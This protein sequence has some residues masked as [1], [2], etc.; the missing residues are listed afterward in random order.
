MNSVLAAVVILGGGW[1]FSKDGGQFTKVE[2]PHDW[3]IGCGFDPEAEGG[4]GK[5]PWC[6]EGVYRR[7]FEI[8]GKP[9]HARLEFDGVMSW[10]EVFVNGKKVGS[11]DYGYVG[12]NCDI[13]GVIREGANEL[14]VKAT[15]KPH[16]SR[17]YPGGGIYR[18]VRLVTAPADHVVP[19]SVFIRAASI[20]RDA[21]TIVCDWEMSKSGSR[22]KTFT[23]EKPHL[24]D[25]EDPYL[26]EVELGGERFRYGIRKAVF[27][28]DDGFH[29]NG[30]RLQLNGV[31]LHSDLGP[32]G[33]AFDRDAAKRQ[34]L[35][36][37]DLGVNAIRTSHNPPDPKFLDLCDEM[38]FVVW[39]E[40]FDKWDE[41]AA[42]KPEQQ[43]EDYVTRNLKA[44]IRRDRNHPSVICWSISNEICSRRGQYGTE[45]SMTKERVR[46]F[47]EAVRSEDTTRPVTA[48]LADLDL[49]NWD[50]TEGLDLAGWNY[51]HSYAGFHAKYPKVP[52]VYSESASAVSSQGYYQFPVSTSKVDFKAAA[53]K[54]D[55]YE[56]H[57]AWCGDI[58][59]VEFNRLDHD[60]YV[61]GEFVWTGMDYLGE[62]CPFCYI[63]TPDCW[64]GETCEE[65]FKPRSSY[66]GIADLIG[67]PK[68]RYWLYRSR[69]NRK[70]ETTAIV[71]GHWNFKVKSLPVEILTSGDEAELFLNGKSLGRKAKA[72]EVEGYPLDFAGR[73]PKRADKY[74]DNEYYRVC[75]KYRIRFEDVAYEPGELK[76]VAYRGGKKIGETAV[77]T[78]GAFDHLEVTADPFTPADSKLRFYRISAVDKAG[79]LVPDADFRVACSLEGPGRILA[80]ANADECDFDNFTK[81]RT[82]RLHAGRALAI[83]RPD[84][85][86]PTALDVV[87][88]K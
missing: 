2:V 12:F 38:G 79:T 24:W 56:L 87:I 47:R 20:T 22:H 35:I 3:A 64:P 21:A 31:N 65:K 80:V 61:A 83:V 42:R 76:A 37:K 6:A 29:L 32:L 26:H 71:P 57:S 19:G 48:G 59:D 13:T 43:L 36:M 30:R 77:K 4:T 60:R 5:L 41:T 69:W 17:W 33:M 8:A 51:R 53:M 81:S 66:F 55:G 9:E 44:F 74:A 88:A 34:L 16:K 78:A 14:V 23:V 45:N 10:P 63:G 72:K 11:W 82:H 84:G 73:N 50:E 75:A 1:E 40:G 27:T 28:A 70:S 54:A 7:S 15:T 67:N 18:E 58:P 46:I 62:P 25:V 68:N 49:I 39:D 85:A 86:S 52:I